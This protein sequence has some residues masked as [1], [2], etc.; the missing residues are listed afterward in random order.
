MG[1]RGSLTY[2][3]K[4]ALSNK[5]RIG[6]SRHDAKIAGTDKDGIFSWSTYNTYVKHCNY[7][8]KWCRD[9]YGCK[10]VEECRQHADEWITSRSH[11]S[12]WTQKLEVAA[13]VKL[14]GDSSEDYVKTADRHRSD[15]KRGRV[16][17][18]RDK[19][20]SESNN[21]EFV[22]FCKSTGLR[23]SEISCLTGDRL[24]W[25]DGDPYIHVTKGTKGGR[26]RISPIIGDNKMEIVAMMKRAGKTH[27]FDRVPNAA[28]I[29]SYR[30][31]YANALYLANERPIEECKKSN[32]VYWCR[33]DRSGTWYD[34]K[35]MMITS[36]ALGHNRIDII[37]SNYLR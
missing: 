27:V 34:K 23:R 29:H 13:L 25:R 37:A 35:A 20:F 36:Q 6:E 15:I 12:A 8:V 24:I 18:V 17:A 3:V 10:T 31:D 19:H 4:Q 28:D 11:L 1:R 5:L 26:E 22:T 32:E 30:A 21:R 16:D 7:F 9:E 2:Q 14:Y 33:R